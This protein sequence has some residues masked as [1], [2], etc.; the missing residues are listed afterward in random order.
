MITNDILNIDNKAYVDTAYHIQIGV[1]RSIDVVVFADNLQEA[2]DIVIDYYEERRAEY[3]GFFFTDDE[4]SVEENIDD[5]IS[6]GNC[7]TYITFTCDEMRVKECSVNDIK[8]YIELDNF[9]S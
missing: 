2:L 7:G 8:L 9:S 3:Q 4:L 5:Y 6:G 1:Y